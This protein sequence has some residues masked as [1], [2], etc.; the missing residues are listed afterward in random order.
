MKTLPHTT[1]PLSQ[2]TPDQ[3]KELAKEL[4][5]EIDGYVCLQLDPTHVAMFSRDVYLERPSGYW[6]R[7]ELIDKGVT[8]PNYIAFESR[9][10]E[11][12]P[13]IW[14]IHKIINTEYRYPV[15]SRTDYYRF[16]VKS[17][18]FKLEFAAGENW[19]ESVIDWG[20]R[21]GFYSQRCDGDQWITTINVVSN[22]KV[23]FNSLTTS[24]PLQ[25]V[26]VL[27]YKNGG[28]SIQTTTH[29][30][31]LSRGKLVSSFIL[32]EM[33]EEQKREYKIR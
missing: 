31:V 26:E 5:V 20:D 29:L 25:L 33:T 28:V 8:D 18:E 6:A 9:Y 12:R 17:K 2:F 11:L 24:H 22:G 15:G 4:P 13:P 32:K 7:Q 1:L 10:E 21:F 19:V 30:Y 3:Q 16:N 23:H 27:P 14:V